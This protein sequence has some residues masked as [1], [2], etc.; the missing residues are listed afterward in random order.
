MAMISAEDS[1]RA[2]HD[3]LDYLVL[4]RILR[5]L[6]GLSLSEIRKYLIVAARKTGVAPVGLAVPTL[7][8]VEHGRKSPADIAGLPEAAIYLLF[9]TPM[10]FAY[11]CQ[12]MEW[13]LRSASAGTDPQA[14]FLF[15]AAMNLLDEALVASKHPRWTLMDHLA[16]KS[17][18]GQLELYR[19]R[20]ADVSRKGMHLEAAQNHFLAPE[21]AM[22]RVMA[23]GPNEAGCG[24]TIVTVRMFVN[25]YFTAFGLS[26]EQGKII[27]RRFVNS[28]VADRVEWMSRKLGD[29]R[30]A[31]NF[32]DAAG[33]IGQ[34]YSSARMLLVSMDV[35]GFGGNPLDWEPPWLAEPASEVRYLANAMSIITSDY[36]TKK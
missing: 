19:A 4:F 36:P 24:E 21:D 5:N 31:Y 33:L 25:A 22:K 13:K 11:R 16:V 14:V 1:L 10:S 34:D 28:M 2:T 3:R 32:G 29:P 17:L 8:R 12:L 15:P 30:P 9:D 6:V 26:T 35:D 20:I 27:A 7:H 23:H 18:A